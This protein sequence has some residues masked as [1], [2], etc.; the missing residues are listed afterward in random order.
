MVSIET[1]KQ[2]SFSFKDVTERPHFGKTSF[3]V[4]GKIFATL[5]IE[6]LKACLKFSPDDQQ[7][8]CLINKAIF[9]VENNWGRNGWTFIQIDKITEELMV[10]AL[11]S[12]FKEVSKTKLKKKK[13]R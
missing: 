4:G 8:Y 1:F 12:A 6:N 3:R 10:E 5:D 13:Q 2:L 7:Q 9:P 11:T